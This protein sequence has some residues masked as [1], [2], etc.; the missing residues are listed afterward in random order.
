MDSF[1]ENNGQKTATLETVKGMCRFYW[2]LNQSNCDGFMEK[3]TALEN[4]V[5]RLEQE[6]RRLRELEEIEWSER[7]RTLKAT[8]S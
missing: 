2:D 3:V 1:D 4:R 8:V 6:V 5:F 7:H